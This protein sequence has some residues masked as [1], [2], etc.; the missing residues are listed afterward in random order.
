MGVPPPP[1]TLITP[2]TQTT[3]TLKVACNASS[4]SLSTD[5]YWLG[6]W[7]VACLPFTWSAGGL[8]IS[9]PGKLFAQITMI[10]WPK[11]CSMCDLL[12]LEVQIRLPGQL[13]R[14][15]TDRL[16][17]RII[18]TS[19]ELQS[20]HYLPPGCPRVTGSL[21]EVRPIGLG[22]WKAHPMHDG[23][24]CCLVLLHVLYMQQAKGLFI[25]Y[26]LGVRQISCMKRQIFRTPPER[27]AQKLESPPTAIRGKAF[28]AVYW[29]KRWKS[30]VKIRIF[31]G[32]KQSAPPPNLPRKNR[33][34]PT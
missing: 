15:I 7:V 12:L 16:T 29:L 10:T 14:N 6:N 31:N 28:L 32:K 25:N 20:G 11:S 2:T 34:P 1:G 4:L 33:F 3:H 22:R 8:P 27:I 5:E 13:T 18:T 30:C 9:F 24:C 23:M 17:D 26:N 21:K 19:S